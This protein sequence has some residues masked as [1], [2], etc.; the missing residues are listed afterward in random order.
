MPAKAVLVEGLPGSGKSTSWRNMPPE[1]CM[2]ITPNGKDMPFL[3]SRRKYTKLD[4]AT[5]SG[6]VITTNELTTL[7]GWLEWINS[8]THIKYVLIDDFTHFFSARVI[9]SAFIA[10]EGY[11][12]WNKFGSDIQTNV[13][14][15]LPTLRDDLTVVFMH[16]VQFSEKEGK[17]VFQT[18][19]KLLDNTIMPV[20]HFTY[21]FHT[22]ILLEDNKK[23]YVLVTNDDGT[24]EA[25][26]PMGCFPEEYVDNDLFE[27]LRRINEY[28]NA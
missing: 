14:N 26:T 21:V 12:K 15:V 23:R 18:S 27:V 9:S 19:G 24:R 28:E 6:N 22:R 11:S 7:K 3:G 17:Y 4:P 8:A 16:H 5:G 1:Q 25:K 20:S 2:V 10:D 13:F